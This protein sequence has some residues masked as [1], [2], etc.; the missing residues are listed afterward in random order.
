MLDKIK[1]ALE[2]VEQDYDI[3]ILY[4]CE[5]GSRAWGFP[6]PDSDYDV[7]FVYVHRL[8]WYL[9]IGK[10]QDTIDKMLPDDLDLGGWELR[11]TLELF[12]GC[13]LALN[14]WL[15]SDILYR[16]P[17]PS[18]AKLQAKIQDYFNGKKA[19]H[20]YYSL[21]TNV[22]EKH[23]H[24]RTISIKK[25]FYV[26]RPIYA[27]LWILKQDTMP[28]TQFQQMLKMGL[29]DEATESWIH[30]TIREK[31]QANEG[32]TI[33]VNET[34]YQW[35]QDKLTQIEQQAF[36]YPAPTDKQTL[37]PLNKLFQEVVA[38]ES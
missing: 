18:V 19:I 9:Q 15:G 33:D 27:C 4:T 35:I 2:K 13:N 36:D 25:L 28:P 24:N 32:Q 17:H 8:P 5:S 26:L 34:A 38:P 29:G 7:R 31:E 10:T 14:E 23:F 16:E 3:Q 22:S 20:H 21:A 6:S 1:A 30:K 12:A 37:E 11:K